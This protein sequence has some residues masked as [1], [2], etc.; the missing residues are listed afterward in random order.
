MTAK[1]IKLNRTNFH[2]F[3]DDLIKAYDEDRLN[4]FICICSYH[5]PENDEKEGFNASIDKYWFSGKLG[6][7]IHSLGLVEIMRQEIIDYIKDANRED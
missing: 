4:D 5:Y 3:I 6:G 7:S 1:I 2:D